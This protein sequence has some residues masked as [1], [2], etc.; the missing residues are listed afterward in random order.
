MLTGIALIFTGESVLGPADLESKNVDLNDKEQLAAY[1]D[2]L[3]AS[4][5]ALLL[6]NYAVAAFIA[7]LV[8]TSIT[9]RYNRKVATPARPA[10]VCGVLLTVAGISNALALPHPLWFVICNVFIYLPMAFAG[11]T[12]VRKK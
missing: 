6:L 3:P 11:Y 12:L 1:I 7:G 9:R 4:A 2:K 10:I 8:A 5:Y